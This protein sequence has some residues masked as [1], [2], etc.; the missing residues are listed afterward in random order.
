MPKLKFDASSNI[1]DLFGKKLVTNKISAIFEL[2]K[3][4]FDADAK[5]VI[6]KLDLKNE[7]LYIIDNGDGMSL[8][9]IKN[10]WMLIGTD[11]KKEKSKTRM[12]RPLNGEK[13]IG[14]FSADRLG[15]KLT[16]TTLADGGN[17]AIQMFFDWTLFEDRDGLTLSDVDIEYRFLNQ[18]KNKGVELQIQNLRDSWDEKQFIFLEKKLRGLLSPFSDLNKFPFEIILDCEEFNYN[19]KRLEPYSLGDISSL[20]INMDIPIDDREKIHYQVYRNGSLI[21]SNIIEN[22]YNFGPIKTRIY[23]FDRGDKVSFSHKFNQHVKDFGN[24]RIY[25]DFFQIYPYGELQ[26]DWLAL[27]ERKSQKHFGRIGNRDLIG[28][29]QIYRD[30]NPHLVDATNRQGLEENQY[31]EE[32]REFITNQALL[33]LEEYFFLRSQMVPEEKAKNNKSEIKK[34][35]KSLNQ[36]AKNI[37]KY[38]R[39]AAEELINYTKLI[40]QQNKEN[41]KIIKSQKNLVDVYKRIASKETLLHGIT[42][43]VLIRIDNMDTAIWNLFDDLNEY[44]VNP[45]LHEILEKYK[46]FMGKEINQINEYLLNARDYLLKKREKIKINIYEK[47]NSSFQ[48]NINSLKSSNIDFQISGPKDLYILIDLKDFKVIFENL[49]SNSIKSLRKI[50]N[51]KREISVNF[52]VTN[53]AINIFFKDNGEGIRPKEVTKIFQP[54][55][56]TNADGYGMG[57][58]IV[59]ELI[60]SNNGEINLVKPNESQSGAEFQISFKIGGSL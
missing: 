34:A 14:R 45:S 2:V 37:K 32:V 28:Y 9:D 39:D 36:I 30:H 22:F 54:F 43:Q 23:S 41:E 33:K 48:E 26:N 6:V 53:Q 15:E 49:I 58:S 20:Y 4:S 3:N 11:H 35:T 19:Q 8:E 1:K 40:Q 18:F 29:V 31:L 46:S 42:H 60:R 7:T 38:D 5:Q 12:G 55:Y 10:K 52:E 13:G 59:D 16:L 24:I 21:E 50:E 27:E 57:L 44:E 56:T 25:R 17:E 47:L 51:V